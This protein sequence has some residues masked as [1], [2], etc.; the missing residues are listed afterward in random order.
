MSEYYVSKYYEIYA[1]C[2]YI[3]EQILLSCNSNLYYILPSLILG[4]GVLR[5]YMSTHDN[6]TCNKISIGTAVVNLVVCYTFVDV[7]MHIAKCML[8]IEKIYLIFL[9]LVLISH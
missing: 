1:L 8:C 9:E 6:Y 2:S 3:E 7:R 5:R 4:R